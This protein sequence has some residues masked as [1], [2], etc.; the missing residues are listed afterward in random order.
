LDE[1]AL[2]AFDKVFAELVHIE[3]DRP[4]T[5]R[6]GILAGFKV[7]EG[8]SKLINALAGPECRILVT[9]GETREPSVEVAHE[10]LFTAWPKLREW[11]GNS[12]DA[13]RLIDY[14]TE[15]AGRWQ[16]GGDNPQ[17]V[18]L[19][20]H[21]AEVSSALRRFGKQA[22]PV[23]DRFLLPQEVLIKQLEQKS[24]SHEQRARIGEI[25]AA[26]GD[27]RPGVGL[28]PDGLPH[29][30][31]VD[32]EGGKVKLEGVKKVFHVKRFRI[33][34]YPVT[35]VQFEAFINAK[36]GYRNAEWWKGIKKSEAHN[37]P[38]WKEANS[39]WENVAW[40]EAVAFCRWLSK[41]TK[42]NIRL[43][44][45]W[46]WQLAATGGDPEREYPWPGAWDA[47]RCNSSESRLRR[48][49]AVGMYP[50]GATQQGVLDMA[51]NVWEWCLNKH[52]QPGTPESLRIDD[53]GVNQRVKRGGSWVNATGGLRSSD[54][55]RP[56]PEFRFAGSVGFRLAQDLE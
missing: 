42:S 12:G 40:F 23:L 49:S 22:S 1:K 17:E 5:R 45:E 28:R 14:A 6:R 13:L 9:G 46:E 53:E 47:T 11:I 52:Q 50:S 24:L 32:I 48:T 18:W 31:W 2:G 55:E 19:A 15:A 4:P 37:Q 51:G 56:N 38:S 33:A 3:R 10:K 41:R 20:T 26:F 54:R 27:P 36:D 25:L 43:P 39:P 7:V 21:V 34:K 8:A 16:N 35:N 30:E 44:T 29:I